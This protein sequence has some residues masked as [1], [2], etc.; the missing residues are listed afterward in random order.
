MSD[1]AVLAARDLCVRY[2]GGPAVLQDVTL[3][4][5]AGERVALVG[6]N[7]AGKS[8]LL[9]ALAGLQPCDGDVRLFGGRTS[10]PGLRARVGFVWQQHALVRRLSALSNAVH[11]LLGTQDGAFAWHAALASRRART[12][13]MEALAAV[14]LADMA[15]RRV[16]RLSGGQAQRVAIARALVRRPDLI[17]AD[18]PAASLD[19]AAGH[20]VMRRLA[21]AAAQKGCALV[22]T[23]HDM[24]HATAYATRV[25]GLRGGRVTLDVLP[26]AFD[27]HRADDLFANPAPMAAE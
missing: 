23:T 18:E 21:R 26:D 3:S 10:V 6:A 4:V 25:I 14:G 22:F 8:T 5:A 9:R 20:E 12:R 27:A 1:D 24:D 13:G 15:A 16:D 2:A 19:P 17:L 11:G 7:G